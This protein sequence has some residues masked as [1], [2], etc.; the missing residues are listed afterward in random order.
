[1]VRDRFERVKPQETA[2][3]LDGMNRTE[4]ARQQLLVVGPALE[5]HEFLIETGEVLRA[6]DQEIV[7]NLLLL[8]HRAPPRR[9]LLC[10]IGLPGRGFMGAR[11]LTAGADRS[12]EPYALDARQRREL[13]DRDPAPPYLG[14]LRRLR[15]DESQPP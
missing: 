9:P 15:L 13:V 11:R 3:P 14:H 7:D 6:L 12:R 10:V 5:R 1:A 8:V 2:G 4:D